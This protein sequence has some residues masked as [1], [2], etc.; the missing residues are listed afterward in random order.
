MINPVYLSR[1]YK[2][3]VSADVRPISRALSSND[4][5]TKSRKYVGFRSYLTDSVC[6][7]A[8]TAI[9]LLCVDREKCVS[10]V[11]S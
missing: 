8:S 6:N 1:G 5:V 3:L 2:K 4:R 9:L 10:L 11:L 7:H